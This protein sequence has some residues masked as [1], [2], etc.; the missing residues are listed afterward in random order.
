LQLAWILVAEK[1]QFIAI[2]LCCFNSF[3]VQCITLIILPTSD[4]Q[5]C[6]QFLNADVCIFLKA[7]YE[8][9]VERVMLTAY[10]PRRQL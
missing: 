9:Q 8:W 3:V 7:L 1:L 2:L 6:E 4:V 10:T 5:L